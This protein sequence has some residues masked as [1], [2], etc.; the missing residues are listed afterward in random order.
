MA[1]KMFSKTEA[2]GLLTIGISWLNQQGLLCGF[3]SSTITWTRGERF[4][5][6]A[7]IKVDI[8]DTP[9][10]I[11][12]NYTQTDTET[13]EKKDFD[14]K[15]SLTSTPCH[16][17]GG[18]WWFVCPLVL[19]GRPCRQ[20]VGKLYKNG[21]Y[22]GCRHCHDL[23]Y[24]SKKAPRRRGW[25]ASFQILELADKAHELEQQIKRR[26]YAGKPTRKQRQVD[27]LYARSSVAYN[28]IN[29]NNILK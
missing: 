15:V 3:R 17:G 27:K 29:W 19:E 22:F 21:D 9:Q 28:Q 2:D 20:R 24:Q 11:T 4:K 14:Y 25:Y 8:L 5:S 10:H 23:T 7:G 12:L 18:R 16:F 26:F 13:G 1:K 6:S